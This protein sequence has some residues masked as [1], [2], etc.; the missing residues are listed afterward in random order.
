MKLIRV[1]GELTPDGTN[2]RMRRLLDRIKQTEDRRKLDVL[3]RAWWR[4]FFKQ[5]E[6]A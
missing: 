2:A 1:N 3:N 4:E 6:A 5:R